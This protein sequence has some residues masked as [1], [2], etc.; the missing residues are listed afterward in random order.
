MNAFFEEEK[1]KIIDYINK[2]QEL[3]ATHFDGKESHSLGKLTINEWNNL[4][5][6][7]I[8]H[9]LNQFGV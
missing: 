1:E 3:G 5:Y 6:K 9:H 8:D 2:T 7:H 4:F